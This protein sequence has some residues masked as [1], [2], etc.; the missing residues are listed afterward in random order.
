MKPYPGVTLRARAVTIPLVR[1]FITAVRRATVLETVL[2]QAMDDD[3]RSG[4][5]EAPIS[6][7]TKVTTPGVVASV[8]GPLQ[9]LVARSDTADH[10]E[11]LSHVSLSSESSAAR[12]AVDCALHDLAAQR[13][14]SP[15][16]RYLGGRSPRVF[17]D[18]TLSVDEP[19][20]LASETR[21]HTAHGFD[22]IKVKL[23]AGGDQVARM[24]AVRRAAGPHVRLRI[25]ANQAFT[26][27]EAV[28]VITA[29]EDAGLNID[30][31]EQPVPAGVW[32]DL[33]YVTRRVNT[34]I[35]ADESV[36]T[37]EDLHRLIDLQAADLVNIKLAKT[38]GVLPAM[39]LA[40]LASSAGLGVLVGCMIE[41]T[42]G[43]GAAASFA[44]SLTE[45]T[46]PTTAAHHIP[47]DLDGGLWVASS[48]VNGGARYDANVI[49]LPERPGLG[50]F[51]AAGQETAL[52]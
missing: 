12:M 22:C 33:A 13:H 34:P 49:T 23:D 11:A 10:A 37:V 9:D 4:W 47:Q 35:M 40:Q 32:E 16:F 30:V 17:T 27:E 51:A 3:G 26:P 6:A 24:R 14:G 50:I 48:P 39:Q 8:H 31:F 5:G 20:A 29:L 52:R 15:L 1:P 19:A 25:D 41:S 45:S 18:M 43:I 36:W 44:A 2:V 7:V 38:G 46:E 28:R 21:Q 42:V